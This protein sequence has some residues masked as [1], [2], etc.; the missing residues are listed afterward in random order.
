MSMSTHVK[1]FI[2]PDDKWMMMKAA[3]DA[4]QSAG[5]EIPESVNNFFDWQ[6][7]T[8]LGK[9]VLLDEAEEEFRDVGVMGI[10]LDISKIPEKVKHIRFYCSW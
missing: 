4:C 1:G 10:T 3:W 5:V 9:E 2:P 8:E 6:E 7:P